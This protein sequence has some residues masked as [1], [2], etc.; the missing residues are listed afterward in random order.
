MNVNDLIKELKTMDGD[1]PIVFKVDGFDFR[2][3]K[4]VTE[5]V[6]RKCIILQ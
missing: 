1:L 5:S 2:Q 3:V 6:I 4:V